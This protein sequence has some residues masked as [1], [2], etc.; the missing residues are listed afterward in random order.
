MNL[1]LQQL[2]TILNCLLKIALQFK[3]NILSTSIKLKFFHL[4]LSEQII[5]LSYF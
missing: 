2:I 5:Y 3:K 1:F 4:E